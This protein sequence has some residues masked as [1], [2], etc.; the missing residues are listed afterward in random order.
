VAVSRSGGCSTNDRGPSAGDFLGIALLPLAL[1][2]GRRWQM[3]R[4]EVR[5][6]NDRK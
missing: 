1:G 6:R 3:R 5:I 4:A 2:L